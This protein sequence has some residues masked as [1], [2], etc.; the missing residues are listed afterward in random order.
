MMEKNGDARPVL[1]DGQLVGHYKIEKKIGSGGMGDIYQAFD[2]KLSRHVAIKTLRP[3]FFADPDRIK[4]FA[5]EAVTAAQINHPHIMSIFDTGEAPLSSGLSL[6][7]IVMEFIEGVAIDT[8]IKDT[9]PA[10]SDL[11]R[12]CEKLASALAAAHKMGIVHR[13]IKAGNVMINADGDP[14]ILDFGLAK[15]MTETAAGAFAGDGAGETIT[16]DVTQES[17]IVGTV[18]YMSPEQA[19]GESVDHRSDIFSFGTLLYYLFTG[20]MPFEGDGR[21]SIIAKILEASHEPVRV[22]DESLPPELERIINK[23][24]QKK[25]EDRYQD[26]RD[27]VVDLRSL[28]RQLD[29]GISDSVS[30][31]YESSRSGPKRAKR[32]LGVPVWAVGALFLLVVSAGIMKL[33]NVPGSSPG[34][35][36][37]GPEKTLAVLNFDNLSNPDDAQRYGQILQE[38][39]LTDL[40]DNSPVRLISSQRLF[41]VQKKLGYRDRVNIGRDIAAE[42]ARESGARMMLSGNLIR[43]ED[44][45]IVTC[46]LIDVIDGTIIT[47]HRLEGTDIF[48]IV[49]SLSG[50]VRDHLSQSTGRGSP[51][52]SIRDKTSVSME[53]F[54]HY[55]A[56]ADLLNETEYE[57]AIAEF[58]AAIEIDPEFNQAY[59]KMAIAQWWSEDTA[60]DAGKESIRRIL[61]QERYSTERERAIATGAL[62]LMEKRYSEACQHYRELTDRYPDDKEAWY[63]LGEALYHYSTQAREEALEAFERA[64]D[65]DVGFALAYRHVFDLYFDFGRYGQA[66]EK[67]N[68]L[69]NVKPESPAGYRYLAVATIYQGDSIQI[70]RAIDRALIHHSNPEDSA[71]LHSALFIAFTRTGSLPKADEYARKTLAA[72]P[73][74]RDSERAGIWSELIRLYARAGQAQTGD[75]ILEVALESNLAL[76]NKFVM[77]TNLAQAY[78]GDF[79]GRKKA[80]E[81]LERG[82]RMDTAGTGSIIWA[83]AG[84][85]SLEERQYDQA[86]QYARKVLDIK[87][88]NH[89]DWAQNI[90]YESYLYSGRYDQALAL[91][92][93]W[94]DKSPDLVSSY[95]NFIQVYVYS[96]QFDAADSV[97]SL[98]GDI[99]G[100]RSKKVMLLRN[101]AVCY[102][103]IGEYGKARELLLEA[104]RLDEDQLQVLMSLG[105]IHELLG[106]YET[107]RD[108]YRN[109][110][111][112][113]PADVTA[114][115]AMA[116]T[117]L[118]ARDFRDAEAWLAKAID[119]DGTDA[120]ALR[121]FGYFYSLQD[122]FDQAL[123]CVRRAITRS[124]SFYNY[125]LL[126]WL[127]VAGDLDIDQGIAL[128]KIALDNPPSGNPFLSYVRESPYVPLPEHTLGLGSLKKGEYDTALG[129]LEAAARLRPDDTNISRD[130]AFCRERLRGSS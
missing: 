85:L 117:S 5:R 33:L 87:S 129:Y 11:L 91:S 110:L 58:T 38:L 92:R 24:L 45:W 108:S 35:P 90:L 10:F 98:A 106:E 7:Y 100:T 36:D 43:A 118:R 6:H 60:S 52:V 46:Q 59:Y 95:L 20:H 56:G 8:Y 72:E 105:K 125:N 97:L 127:Q 28:R 93:G 115:L 29:S 96:G 53:A 65:L 27:L 41:D 62:A 128:A 37:G 44:I 57:N 104:H 111:E 49:D 15:A 22:V 86:E 18:S 120:V 119:V 113:N 40:S 114:M 69:I 31:V 75:S 50:R 84:Q 34:R 121:M 2:R 12:I 9:K 48:N 55:L 130:L 67:A 16:R 23:C 19:R 99:L 102:R 4:R 107:A 94:L 3:D 1:A 78:F 109:I 88:G 51:D 42:V 17:K 54:R 39:I 124:E 14:K 74:M 80:R 112:K 25:P 30:G 122:R 13:D 103:N 70:E 26:T 63:G 64:I 123:A 76:E 116:S 101:T 47:S 77:L 61:E 89:S 81:L 21:V 82:M 71:R 73:S 126:A 83:A 79:Q 66:L 68:H 32:I